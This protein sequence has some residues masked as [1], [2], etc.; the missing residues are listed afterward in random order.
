MERIQTSSWYIITAVLKRYRKNKEE[1]NKNHGPYQRRIEREVKA[2][3]DALAKLTPEEQQVIDV[4]YF[5]GYTVSYEWMT[6]NGYSDR[7]TRRI[8]KKM[9]RLV[10][11]ALGEIR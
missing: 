5:R 7:Q 2:V 3:E 8:C 4:R 10:G 9:V 6:D 11:F 1:Q